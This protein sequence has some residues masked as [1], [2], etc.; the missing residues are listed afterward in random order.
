MGSFLEGQEELVIQASVQGT[1]PLESLQLFEGRKVIAEVR[2]SE[3][4]DLASSNLIRI[5]WQGSRERGRQRRVTWDG[6][7]RVEGCEILKAETFSFDVIADGMTKQSKTEISFLS[8]TTGD[9][10]GLDITLDDASTGSLHFESE[11]GSTTLDLANLSQENPR[12]EFDYG[13][14]DMKLVIE[15]YPAHV[16]TLKLELRHTLKPVKNKRTV[17]FVKATQLDGQMAWAS[18]VWHD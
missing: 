6:Q 16:E 8:K 15:R 10:D 9:R 5:S 13:G 2:P 12:L 1:A 17:Y 11:A 18:P 3:F 7:V 14:V 4:Q